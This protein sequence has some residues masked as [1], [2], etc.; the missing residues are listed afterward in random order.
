MFLLFP[1]CVAVCLTS[2]V[3]VPFPRFLTFDEFLDVQTFFPSY[4]TSARPSL[5]LV[6]Q[7]T[8][9]FITFFRVSDINL[10]FSVQKTQSVVSTATN[11]S[12]KMLHKV[13]HFSR[14]ILGNLNR[15]KLYMY[16]WKLELHLIFKNSETYRVFYLK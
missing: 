6:Y 7:F 2:L 11:A 12:S 5:N 16:L 8:D 13:F 9:I 1:C 10:L 15:K 14:Y 4:F 3:V